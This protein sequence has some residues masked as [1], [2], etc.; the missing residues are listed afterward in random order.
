M[1]NNSREIPE[2]QTM[3]PL[4]LLLLLLLFWPYLAV[5]KHLNEMNLTELLLSFILGV[6][7]NPKT[8]FSSP[9]ISIHTFFA[10]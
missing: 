6:F 2:V 4:L 7:L 5:V 8:Y 3:L 9:K 1:A 10:L